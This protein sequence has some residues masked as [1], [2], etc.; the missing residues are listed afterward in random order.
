MNHHFSLHN[1]FATL[2]TDFYSEV[3]AQAIREPELVDVNHQLAEAIDAQALIADP[4]QLLDW[5]SG[6]HTMPG[7]KPLAMNYS[8]HQFGVF[9]PNLGDGRGL[10][11]G[12]W[13]D[14]QGQLWDLHLK[15][16][17]TT[18]YSR[19][20]DGRAVLRS[21]LR[22]HVIG[23][24]LH[25][26][27]IASTRSLCLISSTEPVVRERMETAACIIR[28]SRSHIRFGSF[29][30]FF[31][32]RQHTQLQ[33]LADYTIARYLPEVSGNPYR[34]LL[35]MAVQRTADMIA[36]WMAEGFCHG[37]MNTDNMSIIGDSFDFGPYAFVDDY[38][39]N[40][41]CNHTDQQGRYAFN[42][43]PNI[44]LWNLNALA[45]ALSPLLD[46]DNIKDCLHQYQPRLMHHNQQ[47]MANKLGLASGEQQQDLSQR[48]LQLLAEHSADYHHSFRQLIQLLEGQAISPAMQQLLDT[49]DAQN[50]L[51]D[52]LAA[53]HNIDQ[54]KRS[55]PLYVARNSLLQKA[56]EQAEQDDYQ[57]LHRLLALLRQPFDEHQ[58]MQHY[59]Q[60]PAEKAVALS[61]SS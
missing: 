50:W 5:A 25:A 3:Q 60:L 38:I 32:Q 19:F 40:H 43:Q 16:A 61:C 42:Q 17:G 34:A 12:E 54:M 51:Q 47:R 35:E 39:P 48:W 33:Q 23:E 44:G 20:G 37:V 29:E 24:A 13:Q 56:I 30:Q 4:Q 53:E 14:Q 27:G 18:P 22:E 11:L 28:V 1:N 6:K 41:I 31:Y 55:N 26:L 9:N 36:G 15:G 59:S 52:Y 57:E 10:L 58:G 21:S 45:H 46:T 49:P 7:S 8:G 2:G